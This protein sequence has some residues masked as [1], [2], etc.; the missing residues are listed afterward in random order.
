MSMVL[1]ISVASGG[2][3][4]ASLNSS[5][6]W[7]LHFAASFHDGKMAASDIFLPSS[8]LE[9]VVQSRISLVN[10]PISS[11]SAQS[12]KDGLITPDDVM[13]REDG[14]RRLLRERVVNGGRFVG[15]VP[16]SPVLEA[17]YASN[18]EEAADLHKQIT[19]KTLTKQSW[20]MIF[21]IKQ[22]R[23]ILQ[24][25]PV[26][27]SSILEAH[28]ET[29]FRL[30][31]Q[32]CQSA[33]K[34][35]KDAGVLLSKRTQ[36]GIEQRID[37]L[38]DAWPTARQTYEEAWEDWGKNERVQRENLLDAM[39]L[40]VCANAGVQEK[41]FLVPRIEQGVLLEQKIP[42]VDLS[43]SKL[44]GIHSRRRD[45]LASLDFPETFL[46]DDQN[47]PYCTVFSNSIFCTKK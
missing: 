45:H 28:P 38:E 1:G 10:L 4:L 35:K 9:K 18:Y 33:K 21:R 2:W 15:S 24:V 30:L 36:E 20:N 11:L 14:A 47:A 16:S 29:L 17:V 22:V 26:L 40:A 44:G 5:G 12:V 42:V 25:V 37:L 46:R 41:Y 32:N 43:A 13:H 8:L 34:K 6:E 39:V 3:V 7:D 23:A 19:G 31:N 27:S